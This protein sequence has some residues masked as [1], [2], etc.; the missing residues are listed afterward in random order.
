M[1]NNLY[2]FFFPNIQRNGT[3]LQALCESLCNLPKSR[4]NPLNAIQP[5]YYLIMS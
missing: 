3:F 5:A 4:L 1:L 2:V